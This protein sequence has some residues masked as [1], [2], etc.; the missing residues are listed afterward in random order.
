LR[1]ILNK[2]GVTKHTLADEIELSNLYV[3]L[4]QRKYPDLI[5]FSV[6]VDPSIETEQW[7]VPSMLF[8]PVLEN[9]IWHGVLPTG[10]PGKI[11]LA[12]TE[13]QHHALNC[14]ISDNGIGY[15]NSLQNKKGNHVSKALE[16]IKIRLGKK[17]S[18]QTQTL[19]NTTDGSSGTIVTML[20]NEDV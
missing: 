1:I 18:I 13:N 14:S 17:G 6:E 4:E 5:Q 7:M 16:L 11:V 3:S 10:K 15:D 8:Q 2:T 20:I 9:A 12:I 19:A